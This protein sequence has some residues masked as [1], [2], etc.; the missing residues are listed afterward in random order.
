MWSDSNQ[1]QIPNKVEW[2]EA[3]MR[4]LPSPSDAHSL[5][6]AQDEKPLVFTLRPEMEAQEPPEARGLSRDQV[7][8]LIS[9]GRG[10]RIL[11]A[12]FTNL[13][14]Y[15]S[16]GDLLVVNTSGTMNAALH[17]TGPDAKELELHLST[18]LPANLWVVELRQ[19]DGNATLPY[20]GARSGDELLLAE[21]GRVVL[22]TPYRADQR[23]RGSDAPVRL[24]VATL[25]IPRPLEDFLDRYGFPIRYKYVREQWPLSY[26]QTMFARERGS[27]EMPS[28]G[29]AFTPAL[30]ERLKARGVQIQSLLLHV[31]VASLESHEPPYEE[32]YRVSVETAQAVN[33]ARSQGRRVIAVGTTVVRA[34]ESSADDDGVVHCGEGY[35]DLVIDS[36][37]GVRV[38]SGLITGLHEPRSSHL[39][40]LEAIAGRQ[41]V[42]R[43]YEEA[44]RAGYRWHEFGDLHLIL[45]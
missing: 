24:W 27:S 7:R 43:A 5:S 34:L 42:R 33:Q 35:T 38:V 20:Y 23:R 26:Y 25:E 6:A 28:A 36:Q 41:H 13:P 29:R 40:M 16:S 14:E 15:L 10:E 17:A 2:A 21:D 4:Y 22:H 1:P 31:G 45:P 9:Y 18:H 30:V 19:L 12:Q 8:L 32:Y 44:L 11:N 37:R 39:M 3:A